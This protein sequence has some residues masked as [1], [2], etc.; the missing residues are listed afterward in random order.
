MSSL[1]IIVCIEMSLFCSWV[2][3]FGLQDDLWE[4]EVVAEH[5]CVFMDENGG[6]HSDMC[7]NERPGLCQTV[8]CKY[9]SFYA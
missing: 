7:V 6:L 3:M 9:I 5:D 1:V 4:G 2:N 8:T